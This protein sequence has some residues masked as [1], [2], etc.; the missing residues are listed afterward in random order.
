MKT[1]TEEAALFCQTYIKCCL[2]FYNFG[3][4]WINLV[5]EGVINAVLP[6][7]VQLQL[8]LTYDRQLISVSFVSCGWHTAWEIWTWR[9]LAFVRFLQIGRGMAVL[10]LRPLMTAHYHHSRAVGQRNTAEMRNVLLK[11][12]FYLTDCPICCLVTTRLL[13]GSCRIFSYNLWCSLLEIC[14]VWAFGHADC[15]CICMLQ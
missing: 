1:V 7:L 6:D 5:T 2:S 4:F 12:V 9:R 14:K 10:A 11:P 8:Q 15:F 13:R 3:P